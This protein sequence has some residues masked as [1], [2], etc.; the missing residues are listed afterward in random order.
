MEEKLEGFSGKFSFSFQG[1]IQNLSGQPSNGSA[2][3]GSEAPG[4]K[5]GS[6][7][8]DN[9]GGWGQPK[10]WIYQARWTPSLS[11]MP[12]TRRSLPLAKDKGASFTIRPQ[13]HWG[14]RAALQLSL[15]PFSA[16]LHMESR[17][18]VSE[19]RGYLSLLSRN[20]FQFSGTLCHSGLAVVPGLG[21]LP[22][23]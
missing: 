3:L 17:P 2:P 7:K 4:C 22:L 23:S 19:V 21:H 9:T 15:E 12:W 16:Q 8:S 14:H 1:F 5:Q 18:Y 11:N 6:A 13:V 20:K 10:D